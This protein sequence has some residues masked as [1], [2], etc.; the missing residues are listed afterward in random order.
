VYVGAIAMNLLITG[1]AGFIGRAVVQEA[2]RRGHRVMAL[3]R[4]EAPAQWQTCADLE[5]IR[6]DLAD[7]R[8]LELSGRGIDVIVHLAASMRGDLAAQ[9]RDTI[10]ATNALLSA[11]RA[12]GIG[13]LIGI[14]SLAVI[15]YCSL[16]PMTLI[17]EASP[18]ALPESLGPYARH[19]L[20]QERLLATYASEAAQGCWLLRPGLVY[21]ASRLGGAHAGL[22]A[23]HLGLLSL[24][25]G[26]V[27]V[28]EREALGRAILQAAEQALRGSR[29]LH[30]VD[31]TLPT[32]REY[33]DALRHRRALPKACLGVP[34]RALAGLGGAMRLALRAAGRP[35]AALP[36]ALQRHAFAARFKP[37]R[38]SGANARRIL[39]WTPGRSSL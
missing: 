10:E 14:G 7:G 19:K 3:I 8:A 27:P 29:V 35:E 28:I 4:S 36:E 31:E 39:S 17:D 38:F 6:C 23:G 33:L 1:A 25:T 32:Q 15:D 21:D 30:L 2:R 16:P 24:H 11:A 18:T 12:A 26:E 13:R 9:R 37:M 20:L 22:L 5:C 34:W